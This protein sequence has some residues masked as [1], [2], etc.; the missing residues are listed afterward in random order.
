MNRTIDYR[1]LLKEGI[2]AGLKKGWS[3]FRWMMKIIIPISLCTA[4]LDWSGLMNHFDFLIKPLMGLLSL[5]PNAALPLAI[6]M[7]SSVYGGMAAM[8]VLPFSTA[9]MTLMAVFILM[10][11]SLIQEGI[12]QGTSGIHPL[13][14]TLV[15]LVAAVVTLLIMAPWVGSSTVMPAAASGALTAHPA[16]PEM[17]RHWAWTTLRLSI[18]IFFIITALLTLLE[19]LKAFDLVHPLVRSLSPFLRLG[20]R[21]KGGIPLDD[22][23]DLRTLLWRSDHRGG[24]E[25]RPPEPRRIGDPPS[26]HRDEPLDGRRPAPLPVDGNPPFLDLFSPSCHGH[27]DGQVVASL[28]ALQPAPPSGRL[29]LPPVAKPGNSCRKRSIAGA[30]TREKSPGKGLLAPRKNFCYNASLRVYG[31]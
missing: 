23:G 19:C 17:L 16:F 10:A 3:G 9:Q 12:I 25:K 14:A 24:G 20:P 4:I 15:R 1:A 6:G 2:V 18:K 26:L 30:Q 29:R 11:H 21:P 8:A 5:P 7:L 13:K 28:A 27:R 22:R 31:F